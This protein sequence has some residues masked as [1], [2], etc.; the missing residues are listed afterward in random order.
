MFPE[1]LVPGKFGKFDLSPVTQ[2]PYGEFRVALQ[3]AQQNADKFRACA[4]ASSAFACRP[5]QGLLPS[6]FGVQ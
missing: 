6:A 5:P 2:I 4:R 1:F 3:R